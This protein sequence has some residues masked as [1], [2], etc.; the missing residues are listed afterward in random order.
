YDHTSVRVVR[1]DLR[2]LGL[3]RQRFRV[4]AS[5]PYNHTTALLRLLLSNDRLRSADL[6]LQRSAANRLV[7]QPPGARHSLLY[8]LSWGMPLPRRA[9]SPPPQADSVLL[10]IRRRGR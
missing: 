9:F 1:T 6:V 5:P 3:P 7:H 4:V 8:E 2:R 10:R